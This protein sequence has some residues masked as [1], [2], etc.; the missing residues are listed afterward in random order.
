VYGA[1]ALQAAPVN[2]KEV[3]TDQEYDPSQ[4]CE[5]LRGSGSAD[6]G[7]SYTERGGLT[8]S[9]MITRSSLPCA[10]WAAHTSSL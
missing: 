1:G 7:T 4:V 9:H 2:T 3:S 10:R 8:N 5:T 6:A